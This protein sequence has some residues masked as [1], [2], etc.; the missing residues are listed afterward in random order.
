[1]NLITQAEYSRIMNVS[2]ESINDKIKRKI[3]IPVIENNRKMIDLDFL[4]LHYFHY[5]YN[6]V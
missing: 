2:R 1:M 3:I 5:L 6:L 4:L